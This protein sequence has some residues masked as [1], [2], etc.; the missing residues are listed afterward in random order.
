MR[1]GLR[2]IPRLIVLLLAADVALALIPLI[3]YA[4]GHPFPRLSNLFNLDT[5]STVPTWYSS[6]QWFCGGAM[7]ALFATHAWHS[8]MRGALSIAVLALACLTFSMDEIAG[9][10]ERLGFA[11]DALMSQGSRQGTALWSTGVWPFVVGLP[12]IGLIA[13][14]VRGTRHIF[15]ARA[16]RAL[17]LV[18]VGFVVMFSGA[19]GVELAAN[20]VPATAPH[21]GLF[22]TQVVVEEFLEMLGVT[23][24]A[25]SASSLLDAYGFELRLPAAVSERRAEVTVRPAAA[26]CASARS[27]GS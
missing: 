26:T 4:A 8:R 25:W 6:M 9:I 11:A 13:L 19:L 21:G 10:H 16:P 22:L 20:L 18:I 5:E 23:L 3:D 2:G 12:A 17:L 7:F 1:A 15:L 14:A 27:A 24:I